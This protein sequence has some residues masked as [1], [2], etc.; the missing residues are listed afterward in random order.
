MRIELTTQQSHTAQPTKA[1]F[2]LFNKRFRS[3]LFQKSIYLNRSYL[4]F[5]KILLNSTTLLSLQIYIIQ[6]K[7]YSDEI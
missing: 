3:R 2:G 1:R 6:Y 5:Y 4:D 7:C